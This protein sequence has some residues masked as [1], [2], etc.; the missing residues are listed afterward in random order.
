[1]DFKQYLINRQS[2]LN[3][4]KKI[5]EVSAKQ[6]NNR[7]ENLKRKGIYNG[8]ERLTESTVEQ[9]N[10]L[11]ADKTN[12]YERTINYYIEFRHYLRNH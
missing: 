6:Y 8:E 11:Y 12:E 2:L 7:L 3:K 10:D 4:G 9:I 1:M 5:G